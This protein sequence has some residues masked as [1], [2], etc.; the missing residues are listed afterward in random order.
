MYHDLDDEHPEHVKARGFDPADY[1]RADDLSQ[2][3]DDKFTVEVHA[4]SPR[5]DPPPGTPHI[6]D[7]VATPPS[8][9]ARPG[10]KGRFGAS[11]TRLS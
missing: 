1:V 3:L 9:T 7:V 6:A 11:S 8:L 4:V 5:I 2:L 10:A